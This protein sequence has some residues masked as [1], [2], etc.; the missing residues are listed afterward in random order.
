MK[1]IIGQQN[2][3]EN[4]NNKQPIQINNKKG[5]ELKEFD[6]IM[7]IDDFE[8]ND[9]PYSEALKKDNRTYS[10]FYISL[11]KTEHL[12]IFAFCKSED[13]NSRAIKI[14]LFI[15]NLVISFT[16]NAL[17]FNDSTMH[18]I[19][20][21]EG[22]F[23]FIYQ[24]PQILYSSVICGV[25]NGIIKILALTE[26]R[27]LELKQEKDNDK[28]KLIL[29]AENIKRIIFY[30]LLSFF[31]LSFSILGISWYYISCFCCIYKNTQLHLIKDTLISFGL[32]S[33]YPFILFLV[34]GIFR[35]SALKAEKKDKE[36]M[37]NFSKILTKI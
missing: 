35:I 12:L 17:F 29:L 25:L 21:D 3:I 24:T 15:L 30:K 11:I 20:E 8:M 9:L 31:I 22:S 37:Y 19:Y 10:E 18:Q 1:K 23:N 33:L 32:S 5:N 4:Q 7:S 27:I 34:P 28:D 16:V 2:I 14:S 13:Y 6:Q 36:Y 26:D